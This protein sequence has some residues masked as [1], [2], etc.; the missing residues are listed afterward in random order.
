MDDER[1]PRKIFMQ[2][3]SNLQSN[4]DVS[5]RNNWILRM[6]DIL[7]SVDHGYLQGQ[8]SVEA[9]NLALPNLEG[10]F[11]CLSFNNDVTRALISTYN[12]RY[13]EIKDLDYLF[14]TFVFLCRLSGEYSLGF[15]LD[16]IRYKI[17]PPENGQVSNYNSAENA[18]HIISEC[19][20]YT[21]LRKK[22]L[23][24][25]GVLNLLKCYDPD[26]MRKLFYF[27]VNVL[28][29]RSFILNVYYA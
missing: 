11:K 9:I 5:N 20:M 17:E 28:K 23:D 26:K 1:L 22:Y 18:E 13:K 12:E 24:D 27:L 25:E 6:K 4:P 21:E 2:M 7:T 19:P 16:K 29:Y 8:N 10:R 15:Y 14:L 3:M